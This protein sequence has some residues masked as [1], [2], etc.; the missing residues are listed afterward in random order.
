MIL[1]VLCLIS[2]LCFVVLIIEKIKD[3]SFGD[4]FVDMYSI[5]RIFLFSN[6]CNGLLY[7]CVAVYIL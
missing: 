7:E 4:C 3:G 1:S 2:F 6:S 5:K